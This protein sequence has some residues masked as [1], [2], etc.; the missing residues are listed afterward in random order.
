MSGLNLRRVVFSVLYLAFLASLVVAQ[1]VTGRGQI[2]GYAVVA[3][4]LPFHLFRHDHIRRIAYRKGRADTIVE[5]AAN[6]V[7]QTGVEHAT[8]RV[9]LAEIAARGT[10]EDYYMD[11]G[12]E[13][14]VGAAELADRMPGSM[15][16]HRRM[17]VAPGVCPA[18]RQDL[19]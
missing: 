1:I 15:L 6:T 12:L 7:P 2:L 19:G 5:V 17:K 11:L 13:M 4:W 10:A 3:A 16:D 14:A 9:L 18:C 8:T